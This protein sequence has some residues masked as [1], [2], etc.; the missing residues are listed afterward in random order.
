MSTIKLKMGSTTTTLSGPSVV[1]KPARRGRPPAKERKYEE[2]AGSYP[3]EVLFYYTRLQY[4]N[5]FIL[6][7]VCVCVC[8]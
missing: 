6:M 5:S 7:C 2:E 8:V 4:P 1:K 3:I